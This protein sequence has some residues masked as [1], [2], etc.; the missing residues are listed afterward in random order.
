MYNYRDLFLFSLIHKHKKDMTRHK[1]R[2]EIKIQLEQDETASS[3]IESQK[4][5]DTHLT[6]VS[7]SAS[8]GEVDEINSS[9]E[10]A[11]PQGISVME[12]VHSVGGVFAWSP[13]NALAA[14]RDVDTTGEISVDL[15]DFIQHPVGVDDMSLRILMTR[16]HMSLTRHK[17]EIPHAVGRNHWDIEGPDGRW[18]VS[19]SEAMMMLR[20]SLDT[21][22]LPAWLGCLDIKGSLDLTH[23]HI[24]AL[25]SSIGGLCV[26]GDLDISHNKIDRLPYSIKSLIVEGSL[27]LAYNHLKRLPSAFGD[28]LVG[29]TLDL[30]HNQLQKL[31]NSIGRIRVKE[32]ILLSHNQLAKLPPTFGALSLEGSLELQRNALQKVP[33]AFKDLFVGQTLRLDRNELTGLPTQCRDMVVLGE[34]WLGCN[35]LQRPLPKGLRNR[36]RM[37]DSSVWCCCGCLKYWIRDAILGANPLSIM[38]FI[39]STFK[40]GA[41]GGWRLARATSVDVSPTTYVLETAATLATYNAVLRNVDRFFRHTPRAWRRHVFNQVLCAHV[42]LALEISYDIKFV[43]LYTYLNYYFIT[44]LNFLAHGALLMW[45]NSFVWHETFDPQDALIE[46]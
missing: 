40:I 29:E 14:A 13:R 6:S 28:I 5:N 10:V 7:L 42:T 34:I 2:N 19:A 3:D 18:R 30:S 9:D 15:L 32:S 31:P 26:H 27:R 4:T 36:V 43:D 25:P 16:L 8:D 41:Y 46:I 45:T 44:L 17:A 1:R 20:R 39:F 37:Y 24:V 12:D 33:K 38:F 22:T 21:E 23:C 35:P 11:T